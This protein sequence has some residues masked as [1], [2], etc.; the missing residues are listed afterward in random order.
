MFIKRI[1]K[2]RNIL[3]ENLGPLENPRFQGWR[4]VVLNPWRIEAL[5]AGLQV[6]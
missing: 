6:R 1:I 2:R 3:F 4:E 5:A